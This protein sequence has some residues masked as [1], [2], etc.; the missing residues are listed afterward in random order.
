VRGGVVMVDG[1][2]RHEIIVLVRDDRGSIN[3]IMLAIGLER[4][5]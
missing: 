1:E 3:K 2:G 4:I 5:R